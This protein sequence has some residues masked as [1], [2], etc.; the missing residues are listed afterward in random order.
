MFTFLFMQNGLSSTPIVKSKHIVFLINDND[1]LN[2][3]AHETIPAFAK[4]LQ[5]QS[6]G[7]YKTTVI[8]GSG[9]NESYEFPNL[10]RIND[11]DLLVIFSRRI[12]LPVQQ[13][14][15]IKSYVSS[16]K[17][18]LGIRTANHGFALMSSMSPAP[19]HVTWDSFV[20]DVLGCE[21]R[22]YGAVEWG[23]NVSTSN[24][25]A[26]HPVLAGVDKRW[27]SIGNVYKVAPLLD[28][29]AN[30]LLYGEANGEIQPIA[31]TR[32]IKGSKSTVFYTSLGH[33]DDFKEKNFTQ[34]LTNAIAWLAEGNKH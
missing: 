6:N 25:N 31:W 27:H 33:P 21:N 18:I 7:K 2:Y 23:T 22:G 9:T 3:M 16:G 26:S 17:P 30:I 24:L 11:A 15:L 32:K 10:E 19:G 14:N 34:L 28:K 29:K 13:V 20:A 1:S 8:L 5:S 12:A 4:F